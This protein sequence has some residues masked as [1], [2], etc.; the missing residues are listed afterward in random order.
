MATLLENHT[1]EWTPAD[2]DR[3]PDHWKVELIDGTLIVNAQPVPR[4]NR[5]MVGLVNLLAESLGP[6]YEGFVEIMLDFDG[7]Q[8]A[9]DVTIASRGAIDQEASVNAPTAVQ[10]AIEVASPSTRAIDT[11]IKAAKY[12]EAGIPGYWRVEPD[13]MRVI[14]YALRD[15]EYVEL[16]SWGPGE[17]VTV[18]EPV[19]VGFDPAVL[20]P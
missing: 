20:L 8:L 9:P 1:G 11:T 17:T 13:P 5:V 2:I 4:H 18:E 15:G 3:M 6:A 10:I 7:S 14:A 16:G 12:A 19:R